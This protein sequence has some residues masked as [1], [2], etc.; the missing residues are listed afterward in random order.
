MPP[1]VPIH[2]YNNIE[3]TSYERGWPGEDKGS[4]GWLGEDEGCR[5]WPGVAAG[6]DPTFSG[7]EGLGAQSAKRFAIF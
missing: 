7:S 4:Q 1:G 3:N 2:F 6:G 5:G